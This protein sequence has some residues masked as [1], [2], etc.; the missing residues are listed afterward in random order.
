M[1]NVT[2]DNTTR[3]IAIKCCPFC[4]N[5]TLQKLGYGG[6]SEDNPTDECFLCETCGLFFSIGSVDAEDYKHMVHANGGE[7]LTEKEREQEFL[8]SFTDGLWTSDENY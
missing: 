4:S 3:S 7:P 2:V 6:E 5:N 1:F 8:G